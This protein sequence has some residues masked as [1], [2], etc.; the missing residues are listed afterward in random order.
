MDVFDFYVYDNRSI[1][2]TAAEPIML[3]DCNVAQFSFHVPKVVNNIDMTGYAWWFVY[4][5]AAG[6]KYSEALTF[7]NDADDPDN[8]MT[9]TYTVDH[10]M[11]ARA[12]T[13]LFAVEAINTQSEEIVNE[14]H[15]MT[16]RLR[17]Y[18]TIQGNQAEYAETES[19]VISAL[20][21]ELQTRVNQLVGG[22]TPLAVSTV[23]EMTDTDSIYVYVGSESGY[24]SGNWY[25]YNGSAWVSGGTYASG[26]VIDSTP[27]ENSTNAISSGAVWNLKE[28]L[29]SAIA[30]ISFDIVVDASGHAT[31]ERSDLTDVSE[32]S[33]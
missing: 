33:Y 11:T 7:E 2:F 21:V 29:E 9:A 24:T 23:A 25:Y 17:V 32:V 22:A 19:D 5:N 20:I 10:G 27:T 6:T 14:W 31:L 8:Y 30:A 1:E 12:G 15:T 13:V 26:I 3:E 18:D 28:D 16:Y 4:V